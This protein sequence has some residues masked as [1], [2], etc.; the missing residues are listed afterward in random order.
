M[1][2]PFTDHCYLY[3]TCYDCDKG[4][5]YLHVGALHSKWSSDVLSIQAATEEANRRPIPYNCSSI[6]ASLRIH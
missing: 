4:Y 1:I 2:A 3:L 6:W 5:S